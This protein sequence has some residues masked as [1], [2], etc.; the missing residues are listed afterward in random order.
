MPYSTEHLLKL[1][2]IQ[3]FPECSFD[4]FWQF[5]PWVKALFTSSILY[6]IV[7][8][9]QNLWQYTE[10]PKFES[11]IGI[12]S[13]SQISASTRGGVSKSFFSSFPVSFRLGTC[14]QLYQFCWCRRFV[15]RDFVTLTPGRK[16]CV[17]L[18]IKSEP[19]QWILT[20]VSTTASQHVVAHTGLLHFG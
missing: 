4:S 12:A 9:S 14:S 10:Y 13:I 19:K 15:L 6:S 7:K 16:I 11:K 8:K 5:K 20:A 1:T 17:Q 3:V 2:T 18:G